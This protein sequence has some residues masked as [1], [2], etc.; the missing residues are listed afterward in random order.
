MD[1]IPVIGLEIH[2]QLK[3]RRKMFCDSP[4]VLGDALPNTAICPVCTGAPGTLPVANQQAIDFTVMAGLALNC[5]IPAE[6]KF[7][8]KSYFY[9][10]L[11]KGYQISQYDQPIAVDGNLVVGEGLIRIERIHLEEDAAKLIHPAGSSASL[12]DFN[13][14]GTPLVEI[15]TRPDFTSPAQAKAFLQE[16]QRIARYLG[17]SDADMEKGQ[18]RC[19]ANVSLK[20]TDND[21][22]YPKTEI[23]NMNSFAS[24]ERA[25]THEIERQGELWEAG[26]PPAVQ[27]TRGWDDARGKTIEQRIKEEAHDYRYFPEPDLPPLRFTPE[28]IALIK[29][30]MPELP[31]ARRD[32]FQT[33]YGFSVADAEVLVSDKRL[34]EYAEQV[35]SELKAWLIAEDPAGGKHHWEHRKAELVKLTG[36]WLVN[37]LLGL[38]N[39][40][41]QG[42]VDTTITPENFAEFIKLLYQGRINQPAAR[43][44]L[45]EM[46]ATGNDPSVIVE[47]K[48]LGLIADEGT[49]SDM[50]DEVLAVNESSVSAYRAGKKQALQF[51][52]GQVMAKTRGRA[53]PKILNTL[54][55]HK[56]R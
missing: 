11:P 43:E 51:L 5:D 46:F 52:V 53:D 6:S 2:I 12:V 22:L 7:D 26:S 47:E 49:L 17:I 39:E 41:K 1:L 30:K 36:G 21:T 33:M 37:K 50:I 19:D 56:L 54:L 55:L 42:I 4:N 13:R 28:H 16:L 29:A 25:L 8:R 38:L 10:D 35:V 48:N 20:P 24:V 40:A 45:K 34:G 31:A 23:K 3:T 14:A 32:R 44:V 27:S 18:L 9:P 15:V